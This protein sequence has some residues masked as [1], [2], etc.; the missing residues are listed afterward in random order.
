MKG[1]IFGLAGVDPVS[2][3]ESG[4]HG[5]WQPPPLARDRT[6]RD[7]FTQGWSHPMIAT[8]SDYTTIR[9]G[10]RVFFFADRL[11]YG[12]GR[13]VDAL[14][15]S[16]RGSFLNYEHADRPTPPEPPQGSSVIGPA[17][18]PE[19]KRIRVV[20][21]FVGDPQL[22]SVGIDMD[23]VLGSPGADA[24]WGLRFWQGL[25][26]QQLGEAETRLLIN[27]FERR[28]ANAIG[29]PGAHRVDSPDVDEL[30]IRFRPDVNRPFSMR[31]LVAGDPPAY[32]SRGAFRHE[33]TLHGL[34]IEEMGLTAGPL[35]AA[36]RLDVFHELS[37]SPPKPAQW[38]DRMDVV[39]SRHYPGRSA[40]DALSFSVAWDIVEAKKDVLSG[41]AT[42]H[43]ASM[44]QLMKYVDFV[45]A[46]YAG[47]NYSAVSAAFVA[48]DF[49]PNIIARREELDQSAEGLLSR[50]YVLNPRE[51]PPT[52]TWA[53]V[54]LLTYAWDEGSESLSL[55]P[56]D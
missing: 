12:I 39:G 41:S 53:S 47:G 34:L 30:A 50:S 18:S 10:D 40:F 19:W 7:W 17:D 44:T 38:A 3:M 5:V 20:V 16:G 29:G 22:F 28:F 48:R 56:V 21:P 45:A 36:T 23:E 46:N 26:F 27:V 8:F 52:R 14:G 32:L 13:V 54:R 1:Y 31:R 9:P 49:G 25:S 33:E 51:I 35:G 55:H 4:L 2:V 43:D 6:P 42:T 11:I 24:A 37:A 15:Q